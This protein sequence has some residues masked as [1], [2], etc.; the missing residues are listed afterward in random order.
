MLPD[1]NNTADLPITHNQV[2]PTD[3]EVTTSKAVPGSRSASDDPFQADSC[4]AQSADLPPDSD[5]EPARSSDCQARGE[6]RDGMAY[7]EWL[8][9]TRSSATI[10]EGITRHVTFKSSATSIILP[11][12]SGEYIMHG[13]VHNHQRFSLL[14]FSGL[15]LVYEREGRQK[16]VKST[17]AG[18]SA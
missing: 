8:L 9:S 2:A 18:P 4:G 15:D 7:L 1:Y 11:E 16:S 3:D 17:G 6:R 12:L 14:S 13:R 10:H 5:P